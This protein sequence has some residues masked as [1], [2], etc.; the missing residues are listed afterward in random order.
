MPVK[1]VLLISGRINII[2]KR[3]NVL[4]LRL[5]FWFSKA[6]R[7]F[8]LTITIHEKSIYFI[9]PAVFYDSN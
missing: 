2:T 6:G 3:K 7:V 5:F 9:Q 1:T 8:N 4:L